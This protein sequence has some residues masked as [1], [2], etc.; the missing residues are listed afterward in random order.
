MKP[1][2]NL[3]LIQSD[4]HRGGWMGCV[5]AGYVHTPNMDALAARGVRFSQAHCSYPLCGPSRMSF[6]TGLHPHRNGLHTNE[7]NLPSDRPTFAHALGLGGY[8]SVLCGRMHFCGVD[9]RHGFVERIFGDYNACYPGGHKAS[10][11]GD[12][13]GAPINGRPA[14][15]AARSAEHTYF[16]DYD[17]GVT[18]A[19][20]D[21]LADYAA[22]NNPKPLALCVGFFNPHSPFM[23][24][25]EYVEAA[26]QRATTMP[27]PQPK[28]ADLNHW[29]RGWLKQQNMEEVTAKDAQEARIQYS[30]LISY[31]DDRIGRVLKAAESLPGETLVLYWSDHGEGVAD[32]GRINKGALDQ[33]S[34]HVPFLV[35]PLQAGACG[36]KD[37]GRVWDSPV[38]LLD[39]APTL[40]E[41]TGSPEIPDADGLSL[42]PVLDGTAERAAWSEREI[43]AEVSI[44]PHLPPARMIRRGRWK[45]LYFHDDRDLLFDLE[46]DPNEQN[47]LLPAPDEGGHG[48]HQKLD[49]AIQALADELK[50]RV[51]AEWDPERERRESQRAWNRR[52]FNVRWG[53]EIGATQWG[54]MEVWPALKSQ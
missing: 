15:D 25:P 40:T 14:M 6:L 45:Y 12:Y 54:L 11:S 19:A 13:S 28:R 51:L 1:V 10:G 35:A 42:V 33:T 32:G 7:D 8:H 48:F 53:Q 9:Q 50:A 5:G 18:C 31:L 44:F 4:Q 38:S 52:S 34:L 16:L 29:E 22:A 26:R 43:F 49:P 36:I 47:N 24:P 20:E 30:A 17:E 41:L 23:A 2:R 39:L 21:Y 27:Q 3:I 37:P 46:T